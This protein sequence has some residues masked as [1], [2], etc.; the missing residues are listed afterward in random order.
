[1]EGRKEERKEGRKEGRKE[2]GRKGGREEGRKEEARKGGREDRRTKERKE[3][4][5]EGRKMGRQGNRD[6]GETNSNR[7]NSEE[8]DSTS[9]ALERK[10]REGLLRK[11]ER[12]A[13]KNEKG[14]TGDGIVG[15][16]KEGAKR[17]EVNEKQK[18]NT[19]LNDKI[20]NGCCEKG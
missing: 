3:G 11:K 8:Y 10:N 13:R 17:K 9:V 19:Q 14:A 5:W 1:M 20:A 2:E 7:T 12:Q 16:E 4:R 18:R 15:G 6:C